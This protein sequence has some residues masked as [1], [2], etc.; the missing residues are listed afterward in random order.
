MF[1]RLLSLFLIFTS[2]HAFAETPEWVNTITLRGDMRLRY[3]F[4]KKES[5][6][7]TPDRHR[8]QI[9]ARLLTEAKPMEETTV[10]IRIATGDTSNV[11]TSNNTTMD[12]AGVDKS[13]WLDQAYIIWTPSENARIIGGKM[14]NPFFSVMKNQLIWDSDWTPEGAAG[15]YSWSNGLFL[16]WGAFWIKERSSGSDNGGPS[17]SG[18]F[19]GQIGWNTE[20]GAAKFTL[21]ASEYSFAGMK[22]KPII[23]PSGSGSNAYTSRGNSSDVVGGNTLYAKDFSI[24]NI[25]VDLSYTR[26]GF[27]AEVAQNTAASRDNMAYLAGFRYGK[28]KERN[29]WMISYS[30]RKTEK[31]AVVAGLKDSDF[32]DGFNDSRGHTVAARYALSAKNYVEIYASMADVEVSVDAKKT[33]RYMAD[34]LMSF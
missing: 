22:G 12:G 34:L 23:N 21:G 8:N 17:D 33:D 4:L 19:G 1:L 14:E 26:L 20:I 30:Y 11:I 3:D 13:V 2:I 5:P 24:A 7:N 31:D 15:L 10:G 27:Y 32:A 18:L 28:I 29:D 25:F 9:R 6:A 16:N